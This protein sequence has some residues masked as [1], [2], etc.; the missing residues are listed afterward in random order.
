MW[1]EGRIGFSNRSCI[2]PRTRI[3]LSKAKQR[4]FSA[5]VG[6]RSTR[7]RWGLETKPYV[8]AAA[9]EAIEGRVNQLA[10]ALNVFV[11][12]DF[13]GLALRMKSIPAT[14][15]TRVCPWVLG[16][17]DTARYRGREDPSMTI[18]TLVLGILDARQPLKSMTRFI[19]V[20]RSSVSS[21]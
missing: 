1:T 20:P 17:S 21:A 13:Y 18:H 5:E 14:D 19:W 9:Q 12:L 8:Q 11:H 6:S 15:C 16:W 2:H 4:K 7:T 10:N 3:L